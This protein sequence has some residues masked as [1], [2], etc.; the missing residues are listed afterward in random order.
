MEPREERPPSFDAYVAA[1]GLAL[2]RLAYLLTG[3]QADAEDLAQSTLLRAMVKWRRVQAADD[4]DRY[5]YK[6]LMTRH[7]DSRRRRSASEHPSGDVELRLSKTAS[8]DSSD[9]LAERQVLKVGLLH[10]SAMQR[11]VLVLR[12]YEDYSDETIS[13]LLSVPPSTVRS[14]AARGLRALRR[15]LERREQEPGNERDVEAGL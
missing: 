8:G 6:I 5:V 13:A 14:H 15:E 12:Y 2:L 11:A 1:R 3:D 10:L 7:T 4:I 9:Q